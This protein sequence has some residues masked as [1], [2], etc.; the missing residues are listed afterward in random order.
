MASPRVRAAMRML[1]ISPADLRGE[2]DSARGA[3]GSSQ[4]RAEM[5]QK[6]RRELV[7]EVEEMASGIADDFAGKLLVADPMA[8]A[9]ESGRMTGFHT[10]RGDPKLADK[11]EALRQQ[12][13][14]DVVRMRETEENR[15]RRAKEEAERDAAARKRIEDM[16]KEQQDKRDA[17][18]KAKEAAA[19]KKQQLIKAASQKRREEAK[20]LMQKLQEGFEKGEEKHRQ[21][22]EQWGGIRVERSEKSATVRQRKEERDIEMQDEMARKYWQKQERVQQRQAG[23]KEQEQPRVDDDEAKFI[24]RINYLRKVAE[25]KQAEREIAF[26]KTLDKMANAREVVDQSFQAR[27]QTS[28]AEA[29]KRTEKQAGRMREIRKQR[30]E[31]NKDILDKL[32]KS[33]A[34]DRAS[35]LR[36]EE[37]ERIKEQR[38]AMDDLVI[39][40]KARLERAEEFAREQMLARILQNQARVDGMKEHQETLLH[41]RRNILKDVLIEKDLCRDMLRTMK[42]PRGPAAAEAPAAEER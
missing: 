35:A 36:T 41:E 19:E 38:E 42:T 37:V 34:V 1:G 11:L 40:N 6:K 3:G 32:S 27:V 30:R 7:L 4:R 26:G 15:L 18:V 31:Q 20:E 8:E 39:Q 17:D 13:K 33:D 2:S 23:R 9:R 29:E 21:T 14:S 28:R 22:M 24:E 25:E 5:Q 16:R 12:A 10:A